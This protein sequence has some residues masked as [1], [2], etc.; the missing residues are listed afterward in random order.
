M[1]AIELARST[2]G[3]PDVRVNAVAAAAAL[4][5]PES[6]DETVAARVQ[7]RRELLSVEAISELAAEQERS[8]TRYL[9]SV[10]GMRYDAALSHHA[11]SSCN[12]LTDPFTGIA[13]NCQ[14]RANHAVRIVASRPV[15]G[16]FDRMSVH[17]TIPDELAEQID[18]LRRIGQHSWRKRSGGFF[19]M[20][21]LQLSKT[22]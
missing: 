4:L 2:S 7:L 21:P 15:L 6:G 12:N 3:L 17:I 1:R 5:S 9:I 11:N 22:K 18:T 8:N 10:N 19:A 20:R 16:Y 13:A 14:G